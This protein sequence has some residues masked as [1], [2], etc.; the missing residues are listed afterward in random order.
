[1]PEIRRTDLPSLF[2]RADPRAL[3]LFALLMTLFMPAIPTPA[4]PAAAN[5]TALRI[6]DVSSGAPST[7]QRA[8]PGPDRQNEDSSQDAASGTAGGRTGE[9]A[10][11]R[12]TDMGC[13]AY[14]GQLPEGMSY[15]PDYTP[16][17]PRLPRRFGEI[18]LSLDSWGLE[19]ERRCLTMAIF[20]EARGEVIV[21]MEAVVWVIANRVARS[22]F[23]DTPCA[24][25]AQKHQFEFMTR[26]RFS[27]QAEALATG[28]MPPRLQAHGQV[29]G[30][31]LT[32]ARA[33]AYQFFDGGLVHDKTLGATHFL[34][35]EVMAE[36]GHMPNWTQAYDLTVEIG[37]HRFYQRPAR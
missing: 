31:A 28:R 14:T 23:P 36:R 19:R 25:I 24:V 12:V 32:I 22:D 3:V 17:G 30:S 9:A 10:S 21:G 6:P 35:P 8:Q 33:L 11:C 13:R 1:M 2:R 26:P 4:G 5:T 34:A 20:G 15:A 7:P 18:V 27:A 37:G 29:E 16:G